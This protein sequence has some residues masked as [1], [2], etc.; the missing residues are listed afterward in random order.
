MSYSYRLRLKYL[1][2]ITMTLGHLAH[3]LLPHK[4]YMFMAMDSVSQIT[5]PLM[6]YFLCEG[7]YKTKN[8][9][10]Y[11]LRLA[12][13]GFLAQIPYS[14]YFGVDNMLNILFSLLLG[15]V[16]LFIY[17]NLEGYIFKIGIVLLFVFPFFFMESRWYTL[18]FILAYLFCRKRNINIMFAFILGGIFY[19]GYNMA[20][21]MHYNVYPRFEIIWVL[22]C[23]CMKII[24]GLLVILGEKKS[25]HNTYSLPASNTNTILNKYLFYVYYP[26]HLTIL[27]L[28]FSRK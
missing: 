16:F 6:L 12:I 8:V 26:V 23:T 10:N 21:F 9:F 7:F 15:L 13:F 14:M 27:L 20:A 4:S 5:Y 19:G 11:G 28:L 25:G 24:S 1:A 17:T 2:I 22:S 18:V 3:G